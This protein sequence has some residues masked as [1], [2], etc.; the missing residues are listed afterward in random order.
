MSIYLVALIT[1]RFQ[2]PATKYILRTDTFRK[3]LSVI[4]DVL[5]RVLCSKIRGENKDR[6]KFIMHAR[7]LLEV[8]DEMD[9]QPPLVT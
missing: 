1:Y 7:R 3:C 6:K 8:C 4:I 9:L 5:S 2:V